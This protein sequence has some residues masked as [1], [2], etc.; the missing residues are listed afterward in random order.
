MAKTA[1]ERVLESISDEEDRKALEGIGSKHRVLQDSVLAQSDYSRKMDE[2]RDKVTLADSWKK[3]REENWLDSDSM[4]KAEKHKADQIAELQAERARLQ[5]QVELGAGENDMTAE[6]LANLLDTRIK[7]RGLVGQSDLDKVI[8][9]KTT[10]LQEF[11]KGTLGFSSQASL[12]VPYLNQ[13]HQQEFGELFDPVEFVKEATSKQRYDLKDYY[14][15]EFV[16][17]KRE[18]KQ[19]SEF[20]AQKA[21]WQEEADAKAKAEFERGKREAEQARVMS[22]GAQIPT[23]DTGPQASAWVRKY[24]QGSNPT[25]EGAAKPPEGTKL[26]DDSIARFAARE[27]AAKQAERVA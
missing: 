25:E 26:G 13:K 6:E 1:W 8:G 11:V 17:G 4:T 21:K 12:V 5:A 3:W 27:L 20:D 15:K 22:Q 10:E 9:D 14:D 23:D 18:A 19:K 24:Y 16:Q 7:E 2:V